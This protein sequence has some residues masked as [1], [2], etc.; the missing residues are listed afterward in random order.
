M[1]KIAFNDS[2]NA[3][4]SVDCVIFGYS[5]GEIKVLLIKNKTEAETAFWSIPSDLIQKNEDL[6][7]AAER[8]LLELTALSNVEMHQARTFL[9]PNSHP[10]GRLINVSYFVL[11]RISDFE[12]KAS[13]ETI[14]WFS[15]NEIE[16]LNPDH[17]LILNSTYKMLKQKLTSES[18]CFDLL[19]EKFTLLDFQKLYEYAFDTVFD[20]ANFRKKIK[21]IPLI[22]LNEIQQNV[23]HRP[24]K[25]FTFDKNTI[26]KGCIFK[27]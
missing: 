15:I 23:K 6:S 10:L 5:E 9:K 3:S 24:A 22:P 14:K 26:D 1:N 11:V 4:L 17:S 25:L 20:K 19:P 7:E 13:K 2:F 27:I 21:Y 12:L 16:V 8:I 18:I